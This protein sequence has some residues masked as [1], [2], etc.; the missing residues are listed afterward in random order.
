MGYNGDD[1]AECLWDWKN[2][3]DVWDDINVNIYK[4]YTI[5]NHETNPPDDPDGN[6]WRDNNCWKWDNVSCWI[7]D[8][9]TPYGNYTYKFGNI[10]FIAL[11][12]EAEKIGG[13]ADMKF[14]NQTTWFS[15]IVQA[16]PDLNIIVLNHIPLSDTT[17]W[18]TKPWPYAGMNP[19]EDAFFRNVIE[20]ESDNVVAYF[21]GHFHYNQYNT[22][23]VVNKP[24]GNGDHGSCLFSNVCG[25][26][27]DNGGSIDSQFLLLKEGSKTISLRSRDHDSLS[28]ININGDGPPD[29]TN[30]EFDLKYPF[31]ITPDLCC[32][33]SLS[34]TEV[35]PGEELCEEFIVENCGEEWS[36]LNWHILSEPEW[37]NW[38]FE[39][40]NGHDLAAGNTVSVQACVI[41]PDKKNKEFK[42]N[43]TIC[44]SD[45]P[46]DLCEINVY[47]KTPRIRN[48]NTRFFYFFQSYFNLLPILRLLL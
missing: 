29:S 23:M 14:E 37:G 4:N 21:N 47:L 15:S 27:T 30:Y 22:E 7:N 35:K 48:I 39:P 31:M 38:S 5:G 18:H 8:S 19:T 3:H 32:E 9:I 46:D 44:N 2:F 40:D 6:G 42:G 20:N 43:I 25:I 26:N 13:N 34:W 16:N 12:V 33:G 36:L 41:A 17:R 45:N 1:F 24:W 11:A 28:W 10:L